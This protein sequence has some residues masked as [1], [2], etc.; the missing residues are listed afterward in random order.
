[1]DQS[2]YVGLLLYYTISLDSLLTAALLPN[3]CVHVA[4]IFASLS[5]STISM[6]VSM[7]WLQ[8]SH[9]RSLLASGR[10]FGPKVR[11]FNAPWSIRLRLHIPHIALSAHT[12][13]SPR[14][15]ST[16]RWRRLWLVAGLHLRPS[17]DSGRCPAAG[18]KERWE[19][20]SCLFLRVSRSSVRCHGR[21]QALPVGGGTDGGIQSR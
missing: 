9:R 4:Q 2:D 19:E 16:R 8:P 5:T 18:Q 17:I 3:L 20:A 21:F 12:L 7:R 15:T 10:L 6:T 1:M 13:M 14:S 11:Y